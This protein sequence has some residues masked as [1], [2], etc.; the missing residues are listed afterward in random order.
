MP[1]AAREVLEVVRAALVD[2]LDLLF[3]GLQIQS[4]LLHHAAYAVD[5]RRG[6]EHVHHILPTA[7]DVVRA[8]AHNHAVARGGELAD[9]LRL[10]PEQVLVG[11]EV[12]AVRRDHFARVHLPGDAEQRHVLL[13][14]VS[15]P[16]QILVDSA[17]IGRDAQNL[18]V[19]KLVA[20][21]LG[22][23]P[24]HAP[25]AAAVAARNRN[26]MIIHSDPSCLFQVIV[27]YPHLNYSKKLDEIN[28]KLHAARKFFC[29]FPS[30]QSKRA[31]RETTLRGAPSRNARTLP[32]AISSSRALVC[33]GA[34]ATCGVR[35]VLGAESSG[36]SGDGGSAESTSA[37]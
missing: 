12:L 3:G 9:D 29:L 11:D 37:M 16:E 2:L 35:I 23:H 14:L 4:V 31:H 18:T 15:L 1:L 27:E 24:A 28:R 7:Q 20:K 13:G 17:L 30:G 21:L 32:T 34:Q 5:H 6:D 22:Q 8:A 36:L 26:H 10:I 19:I 33:L 25:S